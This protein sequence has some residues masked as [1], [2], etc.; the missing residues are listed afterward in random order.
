MHRRRGLV[1]PSPSRHLRRPLGRVLALAASVL[2]FVPASTGARP[3]VVV[4]MTDDQEASST[5]FMP[6]VRRHLTQRGTT[7]K[8][9][10]AS[11]PLCCPSRATYLTGQYAHNHGIFDN[12]SISGGYRVLDHSQTLPVWMQGEGYRTAHVGKYLNGYESVEDVPPGYDEWYGAGDGVHEMYGYEL[13]EN[14]VPVYYGSGL[15][16]YKTDVLADHA[17]DFVRRSAGSGRFFLTFAPT[18]PHDEHLFQKD[19]WRNPRPALRHWGAFADEP[20]P[21]PP[22]FDERD[23]SDKPRW[24]QELPRIGSS[25][26]TALTR[27]Y[28]SRLES[29]LAV[30]EAVGRIVAALREEGELEKTVLLF[31]SDNG[32]HLG[33][34][35]VENKRWPYEESARV[36]LIARGPGIP[37]D[38]RRR[39]VVANVDLAPT[40]L[41]LGD[42]RPTFEVDGLSLLPLAA[43]ASRANDRNVLLEAKLPAADATYEAV[44]TS[45]YVYVD[46]STGA[47][48]LYD[49]SDDP[50]Q[51]RSRHDDPDWEARRKKLRGR[52]ADLRRCRGADCH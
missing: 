6:E 15:T 2:A 29:L 10:F 52:L 41:D 48:E 3:N 1:A 32:F 28:R 20:L 25:K 27:D 14:G 47:E 36:P 39:Q 12:A 21:D 38:A 33:E 30:D 13:I 19:A 26:R 50:Y 45:R 46:Y 35:R 17:V 7:F 5:R 44:R 18:A 16:D 31:T 9:F 40:V 43:D 34:H 49:L 8:R 37:A 42:A 23:V 4:V 22:S 51:L 24:I 11:Y